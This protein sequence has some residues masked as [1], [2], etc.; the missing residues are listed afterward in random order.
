LKIRGDLLKK[1]TYI[2]IGIFS[3]WLVAISPHSSGD[4][5]LAVLFGEFLGMFCFTYLCVLAAS[6][7]KGKFRKSEQ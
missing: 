1:S 6:K 7:V 3:L 5:G 2:Y 4:S